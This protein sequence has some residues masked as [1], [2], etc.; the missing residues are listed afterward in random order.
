L[1][2]KTTKEKDAPSIPPQSPSSM[3]SL[4]SKEMQVT[5]DCT[6]RGAVRVEGRIAGNLRAN[7]VEIVASGSVEGDVE[8]GEVGDSAGAFV[9]DGRVA[10]TVRASHVRVG[11]RGSIEGGIHADEAV[12][13]GHV[14]GGVVARRRLALEKTAKVEGDVYARRIALEEGGMVNG[15]IRMGDQPPPEAGVDVSIERGAPD[16]EKPE[17]KPSPA[18]ARRSVASA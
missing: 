18:D 9:I 11:P 3:H 7:G 10:G 6:S 16:H 2:G 12:I 8:V 14:A 13:H 5:G 1:L 15:A 17:K 4:I